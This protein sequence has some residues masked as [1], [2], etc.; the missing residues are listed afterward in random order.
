MSSIAM[1]KPAP[2][3][4][5]Y[6]E[7]KEEGVKKHGKDA[8]VQS[9][10]DDDDDD[11]EKDARNKEA[12]KDEVHPERKKEGVDLSPRQVIIRTAQRTVKMV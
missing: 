11:H 2:E 12:P 7:R 8:S 9:D 6:S 10:S 5:V 4:E 1:D 3:D